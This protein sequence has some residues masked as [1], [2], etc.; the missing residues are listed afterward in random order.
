MNYGIK[1][2][3]EGELSMLPRNFK[4]GLVILACI[5]IIPMN[6]FGIFLG[7]LFLAFVSICYYME[8]TVNKKIFSDSQLDQYCESLVKDLKTEALNRLNLDE[9]EVR[10]VEPVQVS[11]YDNTSKAWGILYKQG[12]DSMWRSS[13]Y[14]VAVIFC[15][16]DMVHCFVRNFSIIMN[17]SHDSV[18]EYFYRDIVSIKVARDDSNAKNEYIELTA[19]SGTAFKFA[20]KKS[21]SENVN[22]SIGAMRNLIK[23]KKQSMA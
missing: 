23:A 5:F 11:G 20:F 22:R 4:I 2:Y 9:D 14:Q 19:S 6:F 15:S 10:E 12:K 3:F 17:D 8:K 21:D 16:K 13:Q 18:E 7:I 1:R